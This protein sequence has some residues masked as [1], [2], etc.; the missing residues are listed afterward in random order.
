MS[1][2]NGV[3]TAGSRSEPANDA[4]AAVEGLAD[5]AVEWVSNETLRRYTEQLAP[6]GMHG[7]SQTRQ[8]LRAHID[9]LVGAV[10]TYTPEYFQDYVRWLSGAMRTRGIPR[11][12]LA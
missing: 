10:E 9:F 2:S 11:G 8:D 7:R 6:V 3:F 1:E 4:G 12:E 5:T